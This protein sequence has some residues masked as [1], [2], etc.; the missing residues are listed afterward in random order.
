MKRLRF[1]AAVSTL[2]MLGAAGAAQA[3]MATIYGPVYVTKAKGIGHEHEKETK[4]TFR[5]PVTGPGIIVVKNGGDGGK[6]ARVGS[7]RIEL[8]GQ[9]VAKEKD[10]NKTVETKEYNVQLQALNEMEVE[11]ESCR[12]CEIEISVMGEPPAA[13]PTRDPLPTR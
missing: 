6:K 3:Q 1:L 7:A 10:F 4:F 9:E 8:N 2:L 13:L 5:A 12:T 11:V